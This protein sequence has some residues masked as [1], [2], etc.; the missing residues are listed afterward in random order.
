MNRT[1]GRVTAEADVAAVA[2]VETQGGRGPGGS[3]KDVNGEE[4]RW[5][6]WVLEREGRPA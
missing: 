3:E 4:A 2:A 1:R 6:G 5:V